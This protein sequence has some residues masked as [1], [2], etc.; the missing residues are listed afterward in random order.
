MDGNPEDHAAACQG[1]AG[2]RT[3]HTCGRNR[4]PD[5][6]SQ[7][8]VGD[9]AGMFLAGVQRMKGTEEVGNLSVD[10]QNL[11]AVLMVDLEGMDKPYRMRL[12]DT[13]RLN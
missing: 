4:F 9:G 13:G 10:K 1:L 7:V 3:G 6:G 12:R 5:S 2:R 8:L 11:V